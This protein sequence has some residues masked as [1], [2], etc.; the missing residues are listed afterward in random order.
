[1]VSWVTR[2]FAIRYYSPRNV[3]ERGSPFVIIRG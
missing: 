1:M 2:F 3:V